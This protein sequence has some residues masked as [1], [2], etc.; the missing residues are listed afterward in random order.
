MKTDAHPSTTL[1]AVT[2]TADR[3][4]TAEEVTLQRLRMLG[5][6]VLAAAVVLN[7]LQAP[8]TR[9]RTFGSRVLERLDPLDPR[10]ST[11]IAMVSDLL[12]LTDGN[13]P[14]TPK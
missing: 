12:S 9:C 8:L 11:F 14:R 4:R 7:G 6:G 2:T 10:G 1:V 3:T 13:G 5:I